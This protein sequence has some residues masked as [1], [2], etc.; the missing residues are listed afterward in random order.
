VLPI[1]QTH[2]TKGEWQRFR[3]VADQAKRDGFRPP[4]GNDPV[5]T[6]AN[7]RAA[8]EKFRGKS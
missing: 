8:W 1:L 5:D 4:H 3:T 6:L 7:I 2:K